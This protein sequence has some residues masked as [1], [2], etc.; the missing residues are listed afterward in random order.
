MTSHL[1]IVTLVDLQI[2]QHSHVYHFVSE[3]LAL[4]VSNMT[5]AIGQKINLTLAR[6]K[7]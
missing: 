1:W 4:S 3:T 2:W 7:M 5:A 6:L